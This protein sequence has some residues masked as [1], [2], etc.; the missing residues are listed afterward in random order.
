MLRMLKDEDDGTDSDEENFEAVT[1][2]HELWNPE[3]HEDR[4]VVIVK[5]RHI[6]E[7]VDGELEMEDVAPRCEADLA[8]YSGGVG[9]SAAQISHNQFEPHDMFPF[10]PP[11]PQDIPPSSPPLPLSPPPLPLPPS[12]LPPCSASISY[13]SGIDSM[14][15]SDQHVGHCS[16]SVSLASLKPF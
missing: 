2:E 3:E 5:H 1:P 13:T 15:Y 8:S 12:V 14:H 6:L 7:D 16:S 9:W 4:P 11:L 10:V